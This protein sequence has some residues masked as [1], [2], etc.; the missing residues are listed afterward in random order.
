MKKSDRK[1]IFI[2]MIL[3]VFILSIILLILVRDR[4]QNRVE[5]VGIGEPIEFSFS[6]RS[7]NISDFDSGEFSV[8]GWLQVQGTN[9]DVPI[10][11][12]RSYQYNGDITY[13]YGW[14]SPSYVSYEN[15]EVLIGHNMINV[16]STPML[17]NENLMNFEE[18]M[19]FSYYSFAKDNLYIQY[20]KDG[21]NEL[22]L[23]YAIGFYDYGYDDAESFNDDNQVKEY[24]KNARKNSIYDY[25]I[26]VDSKD[27]L[28]SI[29]TCTRYFGINEKQQFI[30]D[31]RKVRMDE[32][33]VRYQVSQNS[34]FSSLTNNYEKS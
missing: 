3:I 13:S 23:I 25:D 4:L 33:T 14:R 16:S 34:N 22:Y 24:I 21:K 27:D 11:D 32:E 20:T 1:I 28:L 31:A 18:L 6:D 19:A 29:K 26:E 30:I 15:R 7:N 2:G 9:I 10:L 5:E 17:P 8:L 12:S